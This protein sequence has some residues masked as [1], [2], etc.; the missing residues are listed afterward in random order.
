MNE[1]KSVP[2]IRFNGFENKWEKKQLNQI[3]K[4]VTRKIVNCKP[5]Y[6]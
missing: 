4:K 5:I 3:V 6:L 1:H 2:N